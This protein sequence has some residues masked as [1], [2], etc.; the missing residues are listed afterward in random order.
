MADLRYGEQFAVDKLGARGVLLVLMGTPWVLIGTGFLIVQMERFSR[1]GPG[2]PLQFMDD[3]PWGGLMWILGG[4]IAIGSALIRK[5]TH[6]DGFGFIGLTIPA[7]IWGACYFW[8]FIANVASEGELGRPNTWIAGT[9]Y[10][11]VTLLITFLSKRLKDE[12]VGE[13]DC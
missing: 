4:A 11:S 7:F 8:S 5:R 2:G 10:W 13:R 12:P 1:P 9:I 3:G 6:E